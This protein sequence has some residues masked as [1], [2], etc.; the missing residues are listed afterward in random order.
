[1][2]SGLDDGTSAH[3][4]VVAPLTDP[5]AQLVKAVMDSGTPGT[6]YSSTI[7]GPNAFV[8]ATAN[9]SSPATV[10]TFTALSAG[11]GGNSITFTVTGGSALTASGSGTLAN[12]GVDALVGCEIPDGQTPISISQVSGYVMVAISDSQKFYWVNPGET[13]IDPLNFASKESSPD[14][15]VSLRAVG[16]QVLVQGEKSTENWYATG[17]IASPFAPIEGRVYARGAIPGTSVVI[18]DGVLLVGDD[19][20][21]YSIGF[22][23]GDGVDAG[24]GVNR[25]SNNGIEERVRRQ[26]RREDGLTP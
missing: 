19:G 9:T 24:W 20:R 13:S 25:I 11:S 17:N 7:G 14:N 1:V 10:V 16:D 4:F 2:F 6:D 8:S 26:L 18:D 15:I 5:M 3:P 23:Q 12:G 21:V 22:Q